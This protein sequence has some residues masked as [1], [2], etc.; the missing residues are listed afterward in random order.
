M[1]RRHI[2]GSRILITGASQGIGYA[3]AVE[4]ARQGGRVLAVARS[5]PLLDE[6]AHKVR[7]NGAVIETVLA[8]ITKPADRAE[9][10]AAAMRHFG[11]LDILVNNAG[12]GETGHFV[13]GKPEQLRRSV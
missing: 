13:E 4:A 7:A 12:I 6:L 3:L 5:Q 8:D 10:V 2:K 9:M 1:A 11:G